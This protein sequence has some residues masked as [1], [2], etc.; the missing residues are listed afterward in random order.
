MG[1]AASTYYDIHVADIHS[2]VQEELSCH[3]LSHR[4][5]VRHCGIGK[6]QGSVMEYGVGEDYFFVLE[7]AY[8]C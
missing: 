6:E 2:P 3:F 4:C 7:Y 5:L 8:F 1:A